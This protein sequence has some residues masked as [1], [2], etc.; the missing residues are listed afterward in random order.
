MPLDE[1]EPR[2]GRYELPLG[3]T[4]VGTGLNAPE[5]FASETIA[6]IAREQVCHLLKPQITLKPRR[7]RMPWSF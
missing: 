1:C 2:P 7:Q 5:G 3:G 4:A 6:E